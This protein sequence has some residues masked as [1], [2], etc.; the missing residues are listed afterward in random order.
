[1]IVAYCDCSVDL[2]LVSVGYVLFRSSNGDE[3]FLDSGVRL[4]NADQCPRQ[5]NWTTMKAEYYAA[6]IATRAALDY[7]NST[8]LLNCDS[9]ET[10]RKIKQDEWNKEAYFPHTLFSFL[11]RYNDWHLSNVD[12]SNNE[13][14]HQQARNGL[15][16]GRDLQNGVL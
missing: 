13:A 14:A 3:E 11:N 5:I 8:L 7:D 12:R 15:R 1:M 9:K 4:L 10:V 2:P 6:I 16:I